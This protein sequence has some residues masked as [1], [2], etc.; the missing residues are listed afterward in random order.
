[1]H[2]FIRTHVEE[3]VQ[4]HPRPEALETPIEVSKETRTYDYGYGE[5][6]YTTTEIKEIV[7]N[8]T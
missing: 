6:S 2:D 4:L 1:M 8:N 7:N 5:R 3:F